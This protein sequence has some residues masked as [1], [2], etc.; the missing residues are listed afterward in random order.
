MLYI[1]CQTLWRK[2]I[3]DETENLP[4]RSDHIWVPRKLV[5]A[6]AAL[7]GFSAVMFFVLGIMAGH[8]TSPSSDASGSN[9]AAMSSVEYAD[10]RLSGVVA[11]QEN[12]R[13]LPDIGAVVILI[14][15]DSKPAKLQFPGLIMPNSFVALDNPVISAISDA[16]GTV[17]RADADGQ[18]NVLVDRQR[19]FYLL[20]LS[21]QRTARG[22]ESSDQQREFI[23]AWF[24]PA[25]KLLRDNDFLWHEIETS[26]ESIDLGVLRFK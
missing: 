20:V 16:G 14:P 22:T 4:H 13:E 18:F 7:I 21:K 5:Y 2:T 12:D 3:E 23:E 9:D 11:V 6:Q 10:C 25:D 26:N 15:K 8:L 24:A 19:S 1:E 17:V